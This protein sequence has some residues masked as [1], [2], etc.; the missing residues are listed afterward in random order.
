MMVPDGEKSQLKG[1]I[2]ILAAYTLSK[3]VPRRD[4]SRPKIRHVTR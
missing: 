4:L 1:L 2:D 3:A